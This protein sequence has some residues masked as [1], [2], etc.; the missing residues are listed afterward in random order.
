MLQNNILGVVIPWDL[1]QQSFWPMVMQGIYY[2]IPLAIIAFIIGI[3]I[4]LV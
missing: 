1:L 4:A 2:T 3:F